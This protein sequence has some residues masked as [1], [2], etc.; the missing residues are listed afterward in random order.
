[1]GTRTINHVSLEPNPV[2]RSCEETVIIIVV[3]VVVIVVV[4]I[5]V[6]DGFP[7]FLSSVDRFV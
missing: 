1:M 7:R 6:G 4:V 3:V 2:D 5:D